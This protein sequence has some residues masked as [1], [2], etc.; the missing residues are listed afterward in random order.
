VASPDP[1]VSWINVYITRRDS[2]TFY[3]AYTLRNVDRYIDWMSE[4]N[5]SA[6]ALKTQG[7][8]PPPAGQILEYDNGRIHIGSFDVDWYTEPFAYELCNPVTNYIQFEKDLSLMGSVDGGMFYGTDSEIV[9]AQGNNP[10]QYKFED[11]ADYGA[12]YGTMQKIKRPD[13][14]HNEKMETSIIFASTKGIC[15]GGSG[16]DLVN[17]TREVYEYDPTD[18]G[19][20]CIRRVIGIDQYIVTLGNN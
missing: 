12:I 18:T 7:L 9:F 8:D 3:R 19:A 5:L 13:I 17:K 16:G 10:R 20:G 1:T 4:D 11:K 14:G 2:E 15:I 6:I